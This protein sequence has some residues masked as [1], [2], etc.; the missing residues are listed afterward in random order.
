M[1]VVGD[2]SRPGCVGALLLRELPVNAASDV[3]L[4]GGLL[5]AASSF[6]ARGVSANNSPFKSERAYT[7]VIS[8]WETKTWQLT[9]LMS[10]RLWTDT[11][12]YS[13]T[14]LPI[15]HVTQG[16]VYCATLRPGSNNAFPSCCVYAMQLPAAVLAA[17]AAASSSSGSSGGGGEDGGSGSSAAAAGSSGGSSGSSRA[18]APGSSNIGTGAMAQG[19]IQVATVGGIGPVGYKHEDTVMLS[20]SDRDRQA[21]V[22]R[23]PIVADTGGRLTVLLTTP[24]ELVMAT[25]GGQV[26]SS[27][28]LPAVEQQQQPEEQ[29]AAAAGS[30]QQQGEPVAPVVHVLQAHATGSRFISLD[31]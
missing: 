17:G 31:L 19:R 29:V 1:S 8:I 7:V 13:M 30:E 3:K 27:A 23:E 20:I 21:W 5:V 24:T 28:L 14:G 9:R 16:I 6:H 18:A 25:E 11:P 12:Q 15:L 26:L 2:S 10:P 22:G 4:V